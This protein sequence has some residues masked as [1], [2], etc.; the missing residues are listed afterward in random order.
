MICIAYGVFIRM[1]KPRR[2]RRTKHV[3]RT[4]GEEKY[5]HGFDGGKL[6]ERAGKTGLDGM[7]ILKQILKNMAE[8]CGL[9][10]LTTGSSGCLLRAR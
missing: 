9:I 1:V 7:M 4:G 5:T 8:G 6:N 2:M 3:A 10:W